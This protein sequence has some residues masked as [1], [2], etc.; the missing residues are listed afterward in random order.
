MPKNDERQCTLLYIRDC[1]GYDDH[2]ANKKRAQH[3][4]TTLRV[5]IESGERERPLLGPC[6]TGHSLPQSG[7]VS[8]RV[9][10]H[11]RLL[12]VSTIIRCIQWSLRIRQSYVFVFASQTNNKIFA[13]SANCSSNQ[14]LVNGTCLNK[15][16]IGE[17]CQVTKQ[18]VGGSSCTSQKICECSAGQTVVNNVCTSQG[19]FYSR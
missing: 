18:C 14:V 10:L 6:R 8:R 1:N 19:F 4:I 9:D 11:G 16:D 15:V 2:S 5:L 12:L 3:L 7:P 13:V 17:N